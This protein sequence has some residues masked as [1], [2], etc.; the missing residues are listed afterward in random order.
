MSINLG[1]CDC[2][3]KEPAIGVAA[4]PGMPMSIAWC[5]KCL[6]AQVIP[7]WAAVANTAMIGGM[8][9]AAPWWCE[10]VERTLAYFSKDRAEFENEVLSEIKAMEKRL[11]EGSDDA[12]PQSCDDAASGLV[13]RQ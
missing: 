13:P 6:D 2:C 12:I 8:D 9:G 3:R 1:L 10:V 5:M 7:Y 4:M 11:G